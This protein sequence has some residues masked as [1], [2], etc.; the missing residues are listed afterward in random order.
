MSIIM[1]ARL[2]LAPLPYAGINQIRFKG[3]E[4]YVS[5]SQPAIIQAPPVTMLTALQCSAKRWSFQLLPPYNAGPS[6][7]MFGE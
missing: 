6:L 5:S 3:F 7:S 1:Q 2:R 4:A